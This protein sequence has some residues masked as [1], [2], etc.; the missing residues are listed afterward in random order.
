MQSLTLSSNVGSSLKEISVWAKVRLPKR[1]P[2]MSWFRASRVVFRS[3]FAPKKWNVTSAP[4]LCRLMSPSYTRTPTPV[5]RG[6]A[7]VCFCFSLCLPGD[8]GDG[9][10]CKRKFIDRRISI[11]RVC[12]GTI[13]ASAQIMNLQ[14]AGGDRG[15]TEQVIV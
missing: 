8:P 6:R 9:T 12:L 11:Y 10:F 2:F 7:C 1:P 3:F 5:A 15:T 13:M 14:N 4:A